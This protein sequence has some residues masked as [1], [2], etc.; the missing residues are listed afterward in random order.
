MDGG[1]FLARQLT[2]AF[3]EYPAL[4]DGHDDRQ[5]ILQ[6][7]LEVF[8]AA[9]RRH[10]DNTR[11]L[12]RVHCLPCEDA[13]CH[14]GL[15]RKLGEEGLVLLADKLRAWEGAL[16]PDGLLEDAQRRLTKDETVVPVGGGNLAVF[17]L[18]VHSGRDIG[19]HGSLSL[20]RGLLAEQL[21]DE[22]RLV[23]APSLAGRGKRLFNGDT[24]L[25][26]FELV[27][28]DRS[29]GC[30]LLHYRRRGQA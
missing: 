13:V 9:T 14:A 11:S 28:S 24:D 1:G 30:L 26:R 27:S 16:D 29:G 25:Q 2:K 22:L 8:L 3:N 21:V 10:M 23:V 15:G 12:L 18:R 6:A 5:V 7:D 19:I 17:E 4:V 20:A